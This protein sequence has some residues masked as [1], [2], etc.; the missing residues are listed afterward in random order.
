[1]SQGNASQY[2]KKEE[3][4]GQIDPVTGQ[5]IGAGEATGEAVEAPGAVGAPGAVPGMEGAGMPTNPI[6]AQ[7]GLER[8]Y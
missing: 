1:V 8:P 7:G 6:P 4:Y 3:M 5:P 2:L